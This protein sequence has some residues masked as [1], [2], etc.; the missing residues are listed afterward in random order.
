VDGLPLKYVP[1]ADEVADV[2]TFLASPRAAYMT[3]TTVT[4][5]GG[6]SA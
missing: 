6:I 1:T 2:I 5:D 4:V 3:G